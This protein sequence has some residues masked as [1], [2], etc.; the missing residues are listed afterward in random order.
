LGWSPERPSTYAIT[1]KVSTL[2]LSDENFM[3]DAG[4]DLNLF[5]EF[6]FEAQEP[7]MYFGGSE[8]NYRL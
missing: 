2:T 5:S 7:Q 1:Q 3:C 4:V 8:V 6:S